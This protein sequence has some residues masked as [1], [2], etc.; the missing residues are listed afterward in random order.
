MQVLFDNLGGKMER[1]LLTGGEVFVR[2][3]IPDVISLLEE[4]KSRV[5]ILTNGTLLTSR[6]IDRLS[7]HTNIIGFGFSI[8][9]LRDS[10][11]KIRGSPNA[12]QRT[13][14]A[15][16]LTSRKFGTS[17]NTVV[18][19]EN[20]DQLKDLLL[21]AKK[22]GAENYII[23]LEMF[24]SAQE[25]ESSAKTLKM[26]STDITLP[27]RERTTYD[28]S[29][30]SFIETKKQLKELSARVGMNFAVSP[31]AADT[32]SEEFHMGQLRERTRLYCGHMWTVRIDPEGN[33]VF[34]QLIRKKFGNLLEQPLSEIWN[35]G[36]LREFRRTLMKNNLLPVCRRCCK[37]LVR[38]HRAAAL[39]DI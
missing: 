2:D 30:E 8:D 36:E 7:G 35:S 32:H 37:I 14:R 19:K 10:H 12:F 13:I 20:L 11:N 24:S 18:F 23:E 27:V 17:V 33:V 3:D 5:A 15:V 22:I 1:I 9:G 29:L 16:E 6:L 26:S 25:V 34:C 21:L 4:R 39:L 28:H 38:R 31:P